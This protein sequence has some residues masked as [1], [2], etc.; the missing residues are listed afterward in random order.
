MK[1]LL[2]SCLFSL[3]SGITLLARTAV[4][5]AATCQIGT[6]NAYSGPRVITYDGSVTQTS[7]DSYWQKTIF[8]CSGA[9]DIV[10]QG[11]SYQG[12]NT[13]LTG[14][15]AFTGLAS[16]NHDLK[17]ICQ[18]VTGPNLDDWGCASPVV[19]ATL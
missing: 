7:T 16:G 3:I 8:T 2:M 12:A 4:S 19:T 14:S 18:G 13:R 11:F 15:A 9:T 5:Q 1:R 10:D 17:L 6:V